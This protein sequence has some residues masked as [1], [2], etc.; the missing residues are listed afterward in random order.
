M[1][2]KYQKADE[3]VREAREALHAAWAAA[4]PRK[5][6]LGPGRRQVRVVVKR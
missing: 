3:K 1:E 5:S 4:R 6:K 2:K